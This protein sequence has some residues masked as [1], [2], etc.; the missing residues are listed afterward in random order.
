MK[1][2][3]IGAMEE[4]VTELKKQMTSVTKHDKANMTFY[5]GNL[6][7]HDT[8]LVVSGIGKVNAAIC[9]QILIDKFNV[10]KIINVGV[11][12]G[13]SK[14]VHPCDMVIA[15]KL[16][17]H[18][19][20][21]TQFDYPKG[22]V[23]RMDTLYFPCDKELCDLAIN[24]CK[25]IDGINVFH[26]PIASGDQFLSNPKL[27]ININKTFGAF[28]GEMEGASIAHV[29]YLNDIPCAV[30]RSISD[31][32]ITGDLMDYDKFSQQAIKHT[33]I[34]IIEMLKNLI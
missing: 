22:Q 4:E 8:V 34:V 15:T 23:P 33:V 28:A 5:E 14:E 31:N 20:D 3:I 9:T 6:L 27:M 7:G 2:G 11:A 30:I 17:Y 10:Q 29:C 1:I 19:V 21:V 12:G 26:Q 16:V 24:A 25:K 18:D 13:L 32:A